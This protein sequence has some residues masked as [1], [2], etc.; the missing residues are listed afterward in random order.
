M[1]KLN[2]FKSKKKTLFNVG[3]VVFWSMKT[4]DN[5]CIGRIKY[6]SES[7]PVTA[8]FD[9]MFYDIKSERLRHATI[10]EIVK[11]GDKTSIVIPYE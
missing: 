10:D 1:N 8:Y 4:K 6:L 7:S 2:I 5:D 3:D 9:P 11:L